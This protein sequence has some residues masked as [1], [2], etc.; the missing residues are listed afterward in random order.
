MS[1]EVDKPLRSDVRFLGRLL[2]E[3]LVEQEGEAL[4]AL[5][6]A[7]RELSIR[8]RRG[9][10]EGR[11]QAAKQLVR[12]LGD[13]TPEQAEPVI[14]AFSVYF[15]LVNIA[16]QH[17]RIRRARSH[18]SEPDAPPQRGS[19][20]AVMI[21]ARKAGVSAEDMRKTIAR[22]TVTLTL[23]AHPTEAARRTVLEKLYRIARR[24]EER[25]RCRLL[26]REEAEAQDAMR[27]EIT[28]LW[29][30]DEVRREKP[31]VGDEVKNALWYVEEILW[32]VMPELPRELGR[33]FRRAYG[34]DLGE[35]PLPLRIHAWPGGDMDGN[36]NVT[37]E[38]V[39][40]A[41]RAY[42]ARGLRR[43]LVSVRE[44]GSTLSQSSRYVDAPAPLLA[45]LE[46][47][48]RHMPAVASQEGAHTDGE[49]WRRKLKFVEAR[50]SAAL[51]VVEQERAAARWIE[52]SLGTIP[53][54]RSG[55]AGASA[56]G[57]LGY[58]YRDGEDLCR[59]LLLVADTLR[60]ANAARA[61]ERRARALAERVRALGLSIAELELRA[62]AEDAV[63]AARW[64]AGGGEETPGGARILATLRKM[65]EAQ[66]EYGERACRTLILS[67]TKSADDM[68]A[69]L[70]CAR[71]AGLWDP[72][73][74]RLTVDIVPL[75][76]T[77]GA[78]Q[79][80]PDILRSLLAHT[81]YRRHLETR[82]T[83]EV[84]VGYSDSGKEV[85]LLA[86][87]GALRNAQVELPRVAREAGIG[88]RIFH[89]RGES[90]ARG[91]GPAQEGIL[92]LPAG[93]VDGHYKATEQGEAL[94]HKYARP[95]LAMRTLE[96][97]IGGALLHTAGAEERP[98][99]ADEAR[100]AAVFDELAEVGRKTY[101]SLVWE[102]PSFIE[103]FS[104]ATPVDELSRMNIGSRPS[105]RSAG[106]LEA[107]RAIPWVFG[108][109]QNRMILPGWYGVGSA[110]EAV[111]SRPGGA[112]MLVE[113]AQRW[114]FFRTVLDNV[115]MVLA[116]SD[117]DI[118]G[119]YA[120]LAPQAARKAIWP[121]I[122]AEHALTARWLKR[123]FGVR[124][125]LESNPTLQRSI[126][127][128]NPYVDPM[129]FLQVSLLRKKRKGCDG[130]DRA[131]LLTI[132]GIAAGMR[133]TG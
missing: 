117:L 57:E 25:D 20:A 120:R 108:W 51:E 1:R 33:A 48:A 21:S 118:G 2:G 4:F 93:S 35:A 36:P 132:N 31:T 68:L 22:L 52:R 72:D 9:P 62:P 106:G 111:G 74:R 7:I 81:E 3:V 86:A 91:G 90:V 114:P 27:E 82:G 56:H 99:A 24:L 119:R 23:T 32:D 133:N 92:A 8:R 54:P 6:E 5:E 89:G 115:Q 128:R 60:M 12:L 67:M 85:G 103:F 11:A 44:L 116:K 37:P 104:T 71:A 102:D 38:V 101:R 105:K 110:L 100:Y 10:R 129:S 69:A 73:K 58:G 53:P 78:L 26:P 18:A 46:E 122:K 42:R 17:H 109:T 34:E 41:L 65:A 50:L 29:Q 49:P 40:D 55:V 87:A 61:G 59:D 66:H 124:K 47:D 84:M 28:T 63:A 113:M 97:I 13:L 76:E 88:L 80:A 107:L 131:I 126:D 98:P 123:I 70:S 15:R 75:F 127:L 95:E 43:L 94:D 64:L 130:C 83:Q 14:R 39:E 121:K 96:L 125:L 19:L 45:S 30:T 77:L 16:E 112:E 79:Q